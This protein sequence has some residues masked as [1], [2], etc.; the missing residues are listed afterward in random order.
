M[1]RASIN[2]IVQVGVETTAGTAVA[3]SK[4][5]PTMDLQLSRTLDV[6]QFRAQGY[7]LNTATQVNKDFGSGRLTGPLNFTE[8]VYPLATIVTPVIT[9]PGGGTLS[10]DWTFTALA[11]G[12]NA[13]KTLT[14]QEGDSTAALQMVYAILTEFGLDWTGDGATVSGS[15]LG[16]SPSAVSLTGG[17]TAIAQLAGS[18]RGADIYMDAVGG[19]FGTT[20]ITDAMNASFSIGNV[21][22][23]K[24]VLN[25]TYTSFM[26]TIETVPTLSAMVETEHNAQ[27]RTLYT[28]ITG[29]TNASR[30]FRFLMT[31]PII[32]AAIAYKFRLD[33]AA[34]VVAME[35]SDIDGVWGYK[36]ELT[37]VY[38]SGFG[39]K[40]FE[41]VVTN[42]L[43]AL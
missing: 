20:K 33:F 31:G 23:P 28:S 40:A 29:V 37:P 22:A 17:P 13:F 42:T 4:Q 10:R 38:D 27:S 35:Q 5:L 39:N 36:Y 14:I 2:R 15:I 24:W 34:Q 8:I 30:L 16:R 7:K 18:P 41:I 43:T 11:S 12:A 9:T 6:A 26:E 1:G 25:T 32:E 21:Q 19:T 3:A